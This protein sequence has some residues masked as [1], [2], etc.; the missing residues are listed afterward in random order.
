MIL[1]KFTLTVAIPA[2]TDYWSGETSVIT[3]S[4]MTELNKLMYRELANELLF[5]KTILYPGEIYKG[6]F[7]PNVYGRV[8][9]LTLDVVKEEDVYFYHIPSKYYVLDKYE[10]IFKF[11]GNKKYLVHCYGIPPN[12]FK[13]PRTNYETPSK[14]Y[15]IFDPETIESESV[16]E[17]NIEGFKLSE[18]SNFI[19][20]EVVTGSVYEIRYPENLFRHLK[21]QY[22][23]Q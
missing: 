20:L 12:L 21:E 8:V 23:E 2:Y 22:D 18:I 19:K 10:E 3:T 11:Q 15:R 7:W 13:W 6:D 16:R 1:E 9:K 17:R 4:S 5:P 14:C